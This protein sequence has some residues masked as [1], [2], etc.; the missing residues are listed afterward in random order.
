MVPLQSAGS[1]R[2]GFAL[3]VWTLLCTVGLVGGG[4]GSAVAR[5]LS[6]PVRAYRLLYQAL[7]FPLGLF[8]Y[9][10]LAVGDFGLAVTDPFLAVT[11]AL[12]VV[13]MATAEFL[14]AL[15]ASG[16][17]LVAYL[18]TVGGVADARDIDL[19]R[20]GAA[21]SMTRY[22][23]G[24][25]AVFAVVF[26]VFRVAIDRGSP[27]LVV[28]VGL[29]LFVVILAGA[30]PWVITAVRTTERPRGAVGDRIDHLRDHAGLGDG[31]GDDGVRGVRVIDTDEEANASAHVRGLG[32]RRYLFVTS[33]FL[34]AFEDDTAVALLA[35]QAGRVHSRSMLRRMS[36]V[37]AAAVPLA[38][39]LSGETVNWTFVALAP[40]A[41]LVGLWLAR[42]GTRIADDVAAERVGPAAVADALARWAA[43]HSLE[44][45][46]RRIPNPISASVPLG[47]RI[48]R[49]R[50]RAE[51]TDGDA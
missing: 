39:G 38:F 3:V 16:V 44:P 12:S 43:F 30:S 32:P 33:T 14:T 17:V 47:D 26:T 18:P 41:L 5:R 35:I 13:E 10:A 25:S 50:E 9:G 1:P 46:R 29:P 22:L 42:R 40:V 20:R 36:G 49:L 48:D 19:T 21:A 45:S 34:D 8:A 2:L 37:V 28:G 6:N 15:A 27:G 51:T 31:V 11:G 7:L 24:I 4:V 23:L